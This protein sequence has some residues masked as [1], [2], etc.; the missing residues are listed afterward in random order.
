M[1]K[2]NISGKGGEGN[3]VRTLCL[4]A[5]C[6]ILFFIFSNIII[7]ITLKTIYEPIDTYK[8]EPEGIGIDIKEARA[9]Y[10]NGYIGGNISNKNSTISKTYIKIDLYTKR[11]VLVGTKYIEINDLKQ[12]QIQEF[13]IGFK[14]TDIDHVNINLVNQVS[15]DVPEEAFISENLSGA[16]LLTTVIFLCFFG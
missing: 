3:R 2:I 10:V 11:N 14:Y 15:E 4:Y 6:V 8:T 5:L 9:T 13:R 7:N 16:V 1:W 12:N